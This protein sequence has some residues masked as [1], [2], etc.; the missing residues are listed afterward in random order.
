[1]TAGIIRTTTTRLSPSVPAQLQV[2]EGHRH[3][4]QHLR[5]RP[6]LP[7]PLHGRRL[8]NA[9]GRRRPAVQALTAPSPADAERVRNG[10][11]FHRGPAA[12]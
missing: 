3:L 8:R 1:M 2:Q 5:P 6:A 4:Q 11:L 9:A 10:R 12:T 7:L